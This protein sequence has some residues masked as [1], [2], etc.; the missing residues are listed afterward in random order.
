MVH[1]LIADRQ[2]ER[3]GLFG[4]LA[5][6]FFSCSI[7]VAVV[8]RPGPLAFVPRDRRGWLFVIVVPCTNGCCLLLL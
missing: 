2:L 6:A 4:G 1:V 7:L 5:V 8:V 3:G